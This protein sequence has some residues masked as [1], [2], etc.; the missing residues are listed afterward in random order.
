MSERRTVLNVYGMTC[1][2][3]ASNVRNALLSV[4]GVK[5]VEVSREEKRVKIHFDSDQLE[6]QDLKRAIT[7]AGYMVG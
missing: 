4:K 3:C 6:E 5:H 2:G 1:E 7:K